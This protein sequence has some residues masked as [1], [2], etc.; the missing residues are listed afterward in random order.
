MHRKTTSLAVIVVV[1]FVALLLPNRSR[2]QLIPDVCKIYFAGKSGIPGPVE[3]LMQERRDS[4]A[5]G[6]LDTGILHQY[7]S[8]S[9]PLL[10]SFN[11]CSYLKY[12]RRHFDD[13]GNDVTERF[14]PYPETFMAVAGPNCPAQDDPRYITAV[15][16]SEG[17]FAQLTAFAEQLASSTQNFDAAFAAGAKQ[18]TCGYRYS[19][20][21][22][23]FAESKEQDY[24]TL[25]K[26]ITTTDAGLR[27]RLESIGFLP[28]A[29]V[30]RG[31]GGTVIFP[32]CSG[33]DL[34]FGNPLNPN[35][36]WRL[37]VEFTPAGL[38]V[39]AYTMFIA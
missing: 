34:R 27:F 25:R 1:S 7:A 5:E 13:R 18:A 26:S 8:V 28:G 9:A 36:S 21:R 3:R 30:F 19:Y 12:E 20:S 37:Y 32:R 31:S 10:G 24:Q 11:V 39:I 16:V 4:A 14:R 29:E 22:P 2:A 15:Y 23:S 35:E 33:Y 38:K 17:V 6:C